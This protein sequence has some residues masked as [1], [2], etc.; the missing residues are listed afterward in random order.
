MKQDKNGQ[1]RIGQS[2]TKQDKT[3]QK[4]TGQ[5]KTKMINHLIASILIDYFSVLLLFPNSIRTHND[6]IHSKKLD[7]HNFC[8][9]KICDVNCA[10]F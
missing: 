3:E 9:P 7:K 10:V 5:N 4:K 8:F 1:N 6:Q 2:R